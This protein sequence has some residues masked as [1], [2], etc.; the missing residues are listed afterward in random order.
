MHRRGHPVEEEI[1]AVREDRGD[2]GADRIAQ[3][4]GHLADPDPGDVGDRVAG[5]GLIG[6]G[7]DPQGSGAGAGRLLGREGPGQ[8]EEQRQESS[9]DRDSSSS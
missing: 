6:P 3:A 7:G 5:T 2:A 4:D 8:E 9:H 1:A